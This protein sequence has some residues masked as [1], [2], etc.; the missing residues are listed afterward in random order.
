M[1][2]SNQNLY[3]FRYNMHVLCGMNGDYGII[4]AN[5]LHWYQYVSIEYVCMWTKTKGHIEFHNKSLFIFALCFSISVYKLHDKYR[6]WLFMSMRI[7][8]HFLFICKSN[9]INSHGVIRRTKIYID[10]FLI[11]TLSASEFI[12]GIFWKRV[13]IYLA[14][15]WIICLNKHKAIEM[16]FL[17]EFLQLKPMGS[18]NKDN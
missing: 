18:P 13:F 1:N 15:F 7:L 17:L 4:M 16:F 6:V 12:F 2:T 8:A 3:V 10:T 9:W 14:I 5:E 11:G